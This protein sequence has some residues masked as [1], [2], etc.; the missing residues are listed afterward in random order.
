MTTIELLYRDEQVDDLQKQCEASG[1]KDFNEFFG[2]A[3][4][5][6]V[7]LIHTV[8]KLIKSNE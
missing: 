7:L 5:L 4:G 8:T 6:F 1:C 3:T 2:K